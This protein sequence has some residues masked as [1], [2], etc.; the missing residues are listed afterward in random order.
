M[1]TPGIIDGVL[2][3]VFIA[4]GAG[5]ANLLL[6]GVIGHGA[7]FNLLLLGATLTYLVYLLRR[8]SAR[9][10]RVVLVAGWGLAGLAGWLLDLTLFQQVVLQAGLIWLARSLYFHGSLLA[11]LLDLGLVATGL[12]AGAWALL[13]TGSAAAALWTFFLLQALFIWIPAFLPRQAGAPFYRRDDA[14]R[15][16][17]AH[18]VAVDAVRKL[19]QP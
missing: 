13:N 10:G 11:A 16:Q 3:A 18:R 4:L 1:K 8:S 14:S 6:G 17:S 7:V 15:F 5:L 19:T 9:V 2:I 12:L